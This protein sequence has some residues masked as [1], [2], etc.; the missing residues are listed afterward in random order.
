[1]C[2]AGAYRDANGRLLTLTPSAAR[3]GG[4]HETTIEFGLAGAARV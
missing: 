2:H 1:V 4:C 3:I